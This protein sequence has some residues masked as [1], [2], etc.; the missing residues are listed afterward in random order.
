M[1]G[2]AHYF[3]PDRTAASVFEK[4]EL[5]DM[6][7]TQLEAEIKRLRR[8]LFGPVDV[9]DEEKP[10]RNPD[11]PTMKPVRLIGEMVANSSKKGWS[12][13]DLFCGSGTTVIACEQLGRRCYAME[14]DP[15]FVD[16]TIRRWEALTG[17]KAKKI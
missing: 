6:T 11:H 3:S 14:L 1:P 9:M 5:K 13:L 16:V 2:D 7:R 4:D 10:S 12:C 15:K 17:R 8:A